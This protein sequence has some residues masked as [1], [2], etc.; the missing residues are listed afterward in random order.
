MRRIHCTEGSSVGFSVHFE[1]KISSS[2]VQTTVSF[3]KTCKQCSLT[4]VHPSLW[5]LSSGLSGFCGNRECQ[6]LGL[7]DVFL[8]Q[9]TPGT[10]KWFSSLRRDA[11]DCLNIMQ[12]QY[13]FISKE[14][15]QYCQLG[16]WPAEREQNVACFYPWNHIAWLVQI[17]N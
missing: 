1:L 15:L 17:L 4:C 7:E 8:S 3:W 9:V 14:D 10:R 5:P 16:P 6:G 13:F 2:D 12:T 11:C